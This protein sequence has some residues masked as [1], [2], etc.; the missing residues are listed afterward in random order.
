MFFKVQFFQG[1][2]FSSSWFFQ[3]QFFL[4]PGFSGS[5][6]F[7]VWF[8]C[9][10]PGFRMGPDFL[11]S[12]VR[13]QVLKVSPNQLSLH[14]K[15]AVRRCSS[16]QLFLKI[17]QYSQEYICVGVS[18]YVSLRLL[19]HLQE[20]LFYRTPLLPTSVRTPCFFLKLFPEL[21]V[22]LY[23]LFHYLNKTLYLKCI[24]STCHFFILFLYCYQAGKYIFKATIEQ[25]VKYFLSHKVNTK[26]R[27]L[28][29][30]MFNLNQ[31]CHLA[32]RFSFLCEISLKFCYTG[33]QSIYSRKR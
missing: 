24:S 20:Q 16:K 7:R 8:Q 5:C 9:P 27:R 11:G 12:R 17:S 19:L 21:F 15:A 23:Y 2:G 33:F 32:E 22:H 6:F 28:T 26:E 1:P 30:H 29:V 14:I 31:C 3:V 4:N 13:V 10:G 25:T 18:F